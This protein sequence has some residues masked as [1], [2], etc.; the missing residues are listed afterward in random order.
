[1]PTVLL[2][3]DLPLEGWPSMDRY[4]H[5]L[6]DWLESTEFGFQVRLAAHIG[7]L[8]RDAGEGPP[9]RRKDRRKAFVRW[10]TQ[11]VDPS[12]LVLPGPLHGPQQWA[13]R[14]HFYP[15]RVKRE[16]KR[17]DV[18]HVLDHSYAHMIASAGRRPVVVTVHDLMPV[19]VLR[20]PTDAGGWRAGVRNRVLRQALKL[21]RQADA[22]I[23]GTHWLKHELASWLGDDKNIHVVPFGVDRAFFG[24]STVARERGRRDWRIPEDAFAI[25]HVGSTVDRKNVPLV[26][27]TLARLRT[28]ADAYLLQ[29]GGRFTA[30]QEALIDR[31]DLRRFVRSVGG[32]DETT[33]RRAYRAA[34]VLLFP[35]L[36]EGFGFP[37][38]EAFASGLPVI[39]SG[40]GGLT[41]VGG[42]A[43]VVVDSR[44]PGAYVEA[45]ER[46]SDD[47]TEREHLVQQGWERAKTFTW[48]RTAAQTADVYR[49]IL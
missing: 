11:P 45:M 23:V 24:E 36:Y 44:D 9:G 17:A 26:M 8:T 19:V 42:D 27:Q 14:Y 2:V 20:S 40:A 21:L 37:V 48:Q 39:T 5:R 1:M 3:P 16:A 18:V 35:S 30:E 41:E 47:V 46:L 13:V 32:A 29:V 31:L 28:Q 25:L 7:A 49:T 10:W 15:W 43:A 33:L 12:R 22:Y 4:A 38:L 34:D 6:H